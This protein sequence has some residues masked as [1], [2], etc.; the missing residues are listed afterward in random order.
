ME[1]K[2]CFIGKIVYNT[3]TDLVCSI[4]GLTYNS[5]GD[6]IVTVRYPS[7][8]GDISQSNNYF[9]HTMKFYNDKICGV[10]P[11]NLKEMY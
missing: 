8:T 7:I 4:E 2:D 11:A 5:L 3:A 10:H 6:I 1:I 9:N